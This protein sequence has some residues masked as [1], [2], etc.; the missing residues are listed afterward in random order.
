MSKSKPSNLTE[1][2]RGKYDTD[3][4]L[5]RRFMKKIKK[6]RILE[7]YRETLRFEKPSEKKRKAKKKRKRNLDK[8]KEEYQRDMNLESDFLKPPIKKKKKGRK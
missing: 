2:P 4:K 5:I 8:L 1:R 6:Y 3:M 7:D